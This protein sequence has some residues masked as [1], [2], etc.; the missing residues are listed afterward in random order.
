MGRA[1]R[2]ISLGFSLCIVNFASLGLKLPSFITL[3]GEKNKDVEN[4]NIIHKIDII[5]MYAF[6]TQQTVNKPLQV[7]LKYAKQLSVY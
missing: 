1:L 2:L 7:H 6:Y 4:V 3:R 5:F